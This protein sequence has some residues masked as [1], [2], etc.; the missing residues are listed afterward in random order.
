VLVC[1]VRPARCSTPVSEPLSVLNSVKA[2]NLNRFVAGEGVADVKGLV[3][4]VLRRPF[5][6]GDPW[7]A[8]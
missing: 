3:K 6:V 5:K 2:W 8:L 4:G 1:F 7:C